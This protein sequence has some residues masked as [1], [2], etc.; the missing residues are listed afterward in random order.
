MSFDSR[1]I[2]Y[3]APGST[4]CLDSI[5]YLSHHRVEYRQ[6]DVSR[7]RDAKRDLVKQSGQD[8]VPALIW[9]K[10]VLVDFSDHDL[11]CFVRRHRAVRQLLFP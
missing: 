4:S 7:D 10:D 1:P 3:V 11:D 6:H 2:L 8:H 5:R 9:D